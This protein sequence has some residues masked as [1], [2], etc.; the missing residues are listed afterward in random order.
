MDTFSGATTGGFEAVRD[1]G[2]QHNAFLV[3]PQT[4][5]SVNSRGGTEG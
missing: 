1:E 4:Y 3:R 2:T 5:R